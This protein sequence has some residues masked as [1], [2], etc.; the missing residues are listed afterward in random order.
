MPNLPIICLLVLLSGT[1][2]AAEL[3]GHYQTTLD[4]QPTELILRSQG[5]QVEGEYV[6]GG[7]LRLKLSG[8]FDGQLLQ[9]QISDPASGQ[10]LAN[11]N[12]SYANDMLNAS[13]AAR[14]P[15]NGA[16][17]MREAL[18]QRVAAAPA[19]SPVN[20][21]QDPALIGTWVHEQI[22]NSS[23]VEFASLNL[24]T[25]LRIRADGSIG[26]W[27]RTVAGGSD[28]SY[29]RPGE[30]QYSGNW[31]SDNGLLLVQL[32]GARDYQPA[33]RY[34]FSEP[35]LVTESNTGKMIWQRR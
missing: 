28:W 27:R 20:P 15:N 13:L 16:T 17:L 25:T 7:Q 8:S 24:V 3:D 31:R 21:A 35:Y 1:S 12:A 5:T 2:L 6:E 10:V 23:G 19:T 22:T 9:A 29:D 11:M 32:E 34:H 18:F 26:Q 4:N 14:D 30:L 33:A